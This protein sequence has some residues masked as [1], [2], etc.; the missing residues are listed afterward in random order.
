M[1]LGSKLYFTMLL[2][3]ILLLLDFASAGRVLWGIGQRAHENAWQRARRT[4]GR[5]GGGVLQQPL[6]HYDRSRDDT[7]PQKFFVNEAFWKRPDGPVFLYIGGEGPLSEFSVLYGHHVDMAVMHGALLVALEHR[8][9]GSSIKP[10]GLETENLSDLSSQQAL[11]DLAEFHQHISSRYDLSPWNTWISFGGSYAGALSAWLRGKFPHLFYGAVASSAPV[12][13]QLDFSAYNRVVAQSLTDESVGGS[14]KCLSAVSEAFAAVVAVL[15]A[16]NET[17]VRKDFTCCETPRSPDDQ[18]EFVRSLADIVMGT[19]QYNEV[20]API[21]IAAIC[22]LMTSKNTAHEEPEGSYSRLVKLVEVYQAVMGRSCLDVSRARTIAELRNT[23]DSVAQSGYRQW[24]YQ[25][26]T[27]FGFFQTCEDSSCPFSSIP[28]WT[29]SL[30]AELCTQLFGIPPK[31]LF[32][33]IAFTNRYYGDIHPRSCRVLYVNG[34]IDPWSKLSIV[35]NSSAVD[36]SRAIV[37]RDTAHCADMNSAHVT[38]RPT[39]RLAKEEIER[40]VA[41]WLKSASW[42]NVD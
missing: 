33:N 41:M 14:D 24:F 8:F 2:V 26:C 23:S 11:A 30:E 13:A 42:E 29:L 37:V 36:R 19:V 35:H 40:H 21:S 16:G 15:K 10:K 18:V 28:G 38:D 1:L 12:R 34:V 20:G 25:T 27:E 6:D 7:F 39:L 4:V 3:V 22:T 5:V 31:I 32:N 9:Y 17:R